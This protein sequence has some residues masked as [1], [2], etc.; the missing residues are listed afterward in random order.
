[1]SSRCLPAAQARPQTI[2]TI[3]LGSIGRA[4][5]LLLT[6][7]FALQAQGTQLSLAWN[8]SPTTTVT[9]YELHYG[10]SS[11]TYGTCSSSVSG[12]C[13]PINAGNALTTTVDLSGGTSGIKYYFA[14]RA[15]DGS[16]N[17]SAYSNEVSWTAPGSAVAPTASFTAS[18]LTGV[19]PLAVAFTSNS[20]GTISSYEWSFGDGA[21]ST[22][23]S[24]SHTFTAAGTYTVTL[25]VTGSS[26]SATSSASKTITVTAATSTT[27]VAAFTPS[28]TSGVAPLAVTFTNNSTGAI[29]SYSW[30]FGDGTTSSAAS[31]SKTYTSPGTYTVTLTVRGSSRS[32]RSTT[33]QTIKVSAGTVSSSSGSGTATVGETSVLPS[34]DSGN[35]NLLVVQDA[36]LSSTATLKSLSFYVTAASGSLRLGVYDATGPG[37]GPGALKAQ[38]NAFTPVVGWNTAKVISP[39]ALPAGKY[40]LAY[41]P[42]SSGL[43]FATNY[44]TGNYR[45]ANLTFGPMPAKFPT[46]NGQ[47][48]THW[49]LYGTL[50]P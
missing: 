13:L 50:T 41:F 3:S 39:V 30:S 4:L 21:T 5:G 38:T 48:V 32:Q 46:V 24:P 10:T 37:G 18:P 15:Y 25:K 33:S 26:A 28:T 12:G 8:A 1:M 40:W 19:A 23:A 11:G 16:G 29:S 27:P 17:K 43:N 44:S 14:I 34:N 7:L 20:S 42:S 22:S 45:Y 31:P 49:S 35:G 9:G 47:G 36:T 6:M 2:P